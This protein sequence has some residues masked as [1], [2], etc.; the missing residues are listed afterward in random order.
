MYTSNDKKREL[1]RLSAFLR[2]HASKRTETVRQ[3]LFFGPETERNVVNY[4]QKKKKT[5]EQTEIGF[6]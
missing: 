1:C 2:K 5:K 4:R 6:P 3:G